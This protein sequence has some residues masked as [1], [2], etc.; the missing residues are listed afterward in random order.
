MGMSPS[1]AH[2]R[3]RGVGGPPDGCDDI[4]EEHVG[5]GNAC[6]CRA[7]RGRVWAGCGRKRARCGRELG[8]C[9]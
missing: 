5:L 6:V 8:E 3:V 7:M 4:L 9:G 2:T 1:P